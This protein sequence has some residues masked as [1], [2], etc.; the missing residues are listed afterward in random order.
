MKIQLLT[1][2]IIDHLP[3]LDSTDGIKL[4]DKIIVCKFFAEYSH[5]PLSWYIF[6]GQK[7][8]NGDYF[9][10]GIFLI[11]GK[12]VSTSHF[13]LSELQPFWLCPR[14]IVERDTRIF[15]QPYKNCR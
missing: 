1:K 5:I 10:K 4:K 8:E 6:E 14:S 15:L 9:L 7:C 2:E 13:L 12:K 3:P 11:N